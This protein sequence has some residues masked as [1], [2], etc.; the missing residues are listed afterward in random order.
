MPSDVRK[1]FDLPIRDT[2]LSGYARPLI[3]NFER[4]ACALYNNSREGPPTCISVGQYKKVICKALDEARSSGGFLIFAYAIMLEHLHLLPNQ[5]GTAADVLRYL[6]GI[7]ARRT[8]DYLRKN[9]FESSLA[10]LR[11]DT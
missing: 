11:H 9:N 10:K 6:K 8:I 7:T 4:Y 2:I 5:P 3:P 1:V